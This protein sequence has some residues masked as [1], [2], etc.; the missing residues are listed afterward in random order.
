MKK[1]L[2]MVKFSNRGSLHMLCGI[3]PESIL[4]ATLNCSR[5]TIPPI[6]SGSGPNNPLPLKS[7][8]VRFFSSPIS[9]G[10]HDLSWLFISIISF[11]LLM[12]PRLAGTQP[13]NLL[14]ASTITETGEFP[15]LS[16]NSKVN[17]L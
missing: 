2:V 1:L 14:F 8:T 10:K 4:L 6:A 9:G 17:L 15:K 3:A 12:L 5:L 11:N 13:W 16:G 7:S